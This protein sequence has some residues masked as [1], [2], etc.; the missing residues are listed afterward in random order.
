MAESF[1]FLSTYPPTQCGLATFSESLASA[2]RDGP[3]SASIG[4]VK[5]IERAEPNYCVMSFIS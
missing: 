4:V 3:G 2:L 1:G 5:V